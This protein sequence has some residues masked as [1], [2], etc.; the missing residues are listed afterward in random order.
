MGRFLIYS[1]ETD[2]SICMWNVRGKEQS[3]TSPCSRV[4]GLGTERRRGMDGK[5]EDGKGQVRDGG[6]WE[7][8]LEKSMRHLSVRHLSDDVAQ[9]VG[10]MGLGFRGETSKEML[11][12]SPTS[13]GITKGGSVDREDRGQPWALQDVKLRG[14]ASQG[15]N[16]A[17]SQ[18]EETQKSVAL[19]TKQMKYLEEDGVVRHVD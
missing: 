18:I 19:E 3:R 17:A 1:E 6:S 15:D 12:K 5:V 8:K 2:N 16:G 13:N 10:H 11:F 9:T 7:V 4:E 14:R